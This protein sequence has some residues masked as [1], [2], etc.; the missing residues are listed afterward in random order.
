[1]SRQDVQNDTGGVDVVRQGLGTGSFDGFDTVGEHGPEDVY[2]L[3]VAAGLAFQFVLNAT[4]GW[5]QVPFLE[6]RTVA[7]GARLA[8]QNR[9]VMQGIVDGFASPEGTGVHADN[10]TILPAFQPISV[11]TYFHRATDR[12]SVNRV[13]VVV[14]PDEAGL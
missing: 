7:Q 9:D 12:A 1:M 11:G 4:Q 5:R 3:A 10:L 2:H 13:S 14:E 8:R 6:G